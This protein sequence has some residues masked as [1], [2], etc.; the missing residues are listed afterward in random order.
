MKIFEYPTQAEA[1][2]ALNQVNAAQS[3]TIK[4]I[5]NPQ[6]APISE[7]DTSKPYTL[8]IETPNGW[9]FIADEFTR[10]VIDRAEVD[11]TPPQTD[12]P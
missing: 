2:A 12:L 9:G 7:I 11:Y 5:G 1:Q 6:H 3:T 10:S 4:Q 8:L